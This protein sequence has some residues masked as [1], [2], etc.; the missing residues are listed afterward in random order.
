MPEEKLTRLTS[1]EEEEGKGLPGGAECHRLRETSLGGVASAEL[2]AAHRDC[3]G[4][5]DWVLL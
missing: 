1:T 3:C 5:K 4:G 2:A